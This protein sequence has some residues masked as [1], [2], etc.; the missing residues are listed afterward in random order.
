MYE[1]SPHKKQVK[2]LDEAE[3]LYKDF[4]TLQASKLCLQF[5][6]TSGSIS[7][8]HHLLEI[9]LLPKMVRYEGVLTF[10]KIPMYIQ[11]QQKA[12]KRIF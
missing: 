5:F 7:N 12:K 9:Y 4:E 8:V 6:L 11:N 1:F 3:E 2:F 10:G